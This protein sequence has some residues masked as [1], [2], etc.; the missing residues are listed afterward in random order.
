MDI[1]VRSGEVDRAYKLLKNP[2]LVLAPASPGTPLREELDDKATSPEPVVTANRAGT[3]EGRVEGSG[4]EGVAIAQELGAGKGDA[5]VVTGERERD[6]DAEKENEDD[7]EGLLSLLTDREGDNEGFRAGSASVGRPTAGSEATAKAD[8]SA[9]ARGDASLPPAS[10]IDPVANEEKV[11]VTGRSGDVGERA[12]SRSKG[13]G[14]VLPR[15]SVE[16][17]TSVLTGFAGVGDKDRA[18]AVFQQARER[19]GMGM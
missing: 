9:D 13:S 10:L 14:G 11:S 6:G 7:V 18:L 1:C 12:A 2:D 5:V 17:F 4:A 19:E 16:A 15:P 8:T 3:R